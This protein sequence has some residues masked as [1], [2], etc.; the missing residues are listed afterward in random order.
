MDVY[1][2][3]V[4]KSGKLKQECQISRDLVRAPW[5]LL[6]LPGVHQHTLIL[7]KGHPTRPLLS[8][9]TFYSFSSKCHT[10]DSRF[11]VGIW[12]DTDSIHN[13]FQY[14]LS[15]NYYCSVFPHWHG[16][17]GNRFMVMVRPLKRGPFHKAS[18]YLWL[19]IY[20]SI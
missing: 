10:G 17:G 12:K 19:V 14:F 16:E 6:A 20:F 13:I 18:I 1:L 11:Y 15:P 2:I 5:L 9:I 7:L 8:L 4:L 3:T